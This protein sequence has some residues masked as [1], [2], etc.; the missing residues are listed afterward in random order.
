L[1]AGLSLNPTTGAITGVPAANTAGAYVITVTATDTAQIPVTGSVTFTVTVTGGL[2]MTPAGV[3]IAGEFGTPSAISAAIIPT[4]GTYPYHFTI[5]APGALPKEMTID[6]LTG[7]VSISDLTPAGTFTITI[8]ATDST[9]GTHLT[10]NI[11]FDVVVNFKMTNTAPVASTL[12]ADVLTTVTATGN[13]GTIIYTLDAASLT[14]GFLINASSGAVT[15]G[16]AVAADSGNIT[17]TA[18]DSVTKATG[19]SNLAKGF[20]TGSKTIAVTVN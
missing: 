2:V 9:P 14:K 20:G 4:G 13:S 3:N 6:D 18:T 1:P 5:T 10:G 17:V 11:T 8:T 7:V 16:T 15:Q 12:P 19:A